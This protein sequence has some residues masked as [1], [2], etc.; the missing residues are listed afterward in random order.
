MKKYILGTLSFLCLSMSLSAQIF[1]DA[2]DELVEEGF[3]HETSFFKSSKNYL[4]ELSSNPGV[5]GISDEDPDPA[6]IDDY[7]PYLLVGAIGI[8]V[9]NRNKILV[10]VKH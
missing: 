2:D 5:I 8:V 1:D 6:P 10:K 9:F 7:I 4:D 3:E